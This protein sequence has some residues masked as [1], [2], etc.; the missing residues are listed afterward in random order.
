LVKALT[1]GLAVLLLAS[2]GLN[3]AVR[4]GAVTR[5]PLEY[6][7]DMAR[8]VRYNAFEANPNFPNGMT[9]RVPPAG[10]I[11]RGLLPVSSDPT[12]NVDGTPTNPFTPDDAAA[13][14][15]GTV[16]FNTYCVPCHSA[17]GEGDGL[18]VQHGFPAPPSLLRA[19]T[20]AMDDSRIFDIISS[21]SG[22]MPSYAAQ[23]ARED[24][25]KAVLHVRELQNG[26]Q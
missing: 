18:V 7:P 4:Q 23:I 1:I 13:V 20:K 3:I 9:L 14:A 12:I 26:A 5:T 25:W 8:T 19:R 16:V 2:I 10:T 17:S 22:T 6:F 15:R 24:R 11:P 21:G